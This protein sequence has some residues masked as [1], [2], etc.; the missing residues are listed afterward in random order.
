MNT[1]TKAS[2]SQRTFFCKFLTF[3]GL[4]LQHLAPNA[5]LQLASFVVL[6]EGFLGIEP[7]LDLWQSLLFFK[8]QSKKMDKADVEKL[9]GP[10]PMTPCAAALVHH[11]TKCG[12]PQMPLQDCI[13]QWQRGFFY[14]KNAIPTRD[15]ITCPPSPS[16]LRRRRR[17][18]KQSRD[19]LTTMITRRILPLQ[20]QTHLIFQMSGRHDPCWLSTKN[21]HP[22]AVA[23][24]VNQISSANIDEGGDWAWGLV[25]YDRNYLPPML[26]E[27][28]PLA[29]EVETSDPSEI[30]DEGMIELRYAVLGEALESEGS[31]PSGEHMRPP[32]VDWT[33]DDETP[34]SSYDAAFREDAEEV[35]EVTSPSMTRGHRNAGE[36]S[37]L[38]EAAKNKGKGATTSKSASKRVAPGPPAGGQAGGAKKHRAGASRKLVPVVAVEAEDVEEETASVAERAGWA[39]A[40]AAQKALDDQSTL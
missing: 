29:P 13:K 37:A 12:F 2:G 11:R 30:E 39:V 38:G 26:Q 24:I 8:Q 27:L 32:L 9:D 19:L 10:R 18:G 3:F 20:R 35:E 5:I 23:K 31:E 15:A 40:E 28:T 33:D 4:L 22:R 36:T 7:R 16:R 25:P 14:V 21:F 34:P 6:C 17:T 1:S